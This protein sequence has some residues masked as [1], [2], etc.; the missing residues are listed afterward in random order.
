MV[1]SSVSEGTF[2][3]T[4]DSPSGSHQSISWASIV[5]SASMKRRFAPPSPQSAG[6]KPGWRVAER[7]T[8]TGKFASVVVTMP[9]AGRMDRLVSKSS[10][11]N[12]YT[13]L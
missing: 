9:S 6:A 3:Q 11:S 10:I 7:R 12:L 13:I 4:V 1:V 5:P 8:R 2:T